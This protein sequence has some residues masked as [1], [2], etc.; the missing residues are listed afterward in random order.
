MYP[1]L[2]NAQA[3]H[4]IGRAAGCAPREAAQATPMPNSSS[5]VLSANVSSRLRKVAGSN[6]TIYESST[7]AGTTR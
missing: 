7:M 2:E 3:N 5:I 4:K 6:G 1:A